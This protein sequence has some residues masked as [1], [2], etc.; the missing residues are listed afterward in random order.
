MPHSQVTI[1]RVNPALPSNVKHTVLART[2]NSELRVAIT[3]LT[4]VCIPGQA[5]PTAFGNG[6]QGVYVPVDMRSFA[7]FR[8]CTYYAPPALAVYLGFKSPAASSRGLH[9]EHTL[10]GERCIL[11]GTDPRFVFKVRASST[12]SPL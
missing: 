7:G 4:L 10:P 5:G 12:S 2:V 9:V 1:C 8:W 6:L 11:A 3:D